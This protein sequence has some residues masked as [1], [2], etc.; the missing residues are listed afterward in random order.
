[1]LSLLIHAAPL[2]RPPPTRQPVVAAN[3]TVQP[4]HVHWSGGEL[5]AYRQGFEAGHK[6]GHQLGF[7]RGNRTGYDRGWDEGFEGS[8]VL[9]KL[10]G[11]MK[12]PNKTLQ[13]LLFV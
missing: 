10:L 4:P 8:Q 2:T 9:G 7:E 12:F 3:T 1:M 13:V 11:E 6:N 5:R